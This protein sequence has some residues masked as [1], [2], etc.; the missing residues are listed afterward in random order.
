MSKSE[1]KQLIKDSI[2]E[3]LK[4]DQSVDLVVN[5]IYHHFIDKQEFQEILIGFLEL[6]SL[7]NLKFMIRKELDNLNG[8]F[9]FKNKNLDSKIYL[10]SIDNVY[11]TYSNSKISILLKISNKDLKISSYLSINEN[12]VKIHLSNKIDLNNKEEVIKAFKKKSCVVYY[13]E[14]I[15]KFTFIELL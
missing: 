9:Y 7:E 2:E 4:Q 10:F 8:N 6:K 12:D 13:E 1:Y 15:Q 5:Y 3:L 14:F 11:V